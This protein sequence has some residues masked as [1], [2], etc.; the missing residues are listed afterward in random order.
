MAAFSDIILLI[1]CSN[2]CAFGSEDFLGGDILLKGG[3]GGGGGADDTIELK[4][5]GATNTDCFLLG[6]CGTYLDGLSAVLH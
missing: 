4:P 5:D 6:N 3:G 1:C 2:I